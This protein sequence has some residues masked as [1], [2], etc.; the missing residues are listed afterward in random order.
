MNQEG[1]HSWFD[2][3]FVKLFAEKTAE[4]L[5]S[6]RMCRM[7]FSNSEINTQMYQNRGEKSTKNSVGG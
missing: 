3:N 1:G 7:V 6:V 4:K 2:Q 5:L